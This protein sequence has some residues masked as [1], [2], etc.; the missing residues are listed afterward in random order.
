MDLKIVNEADVTPELNQA[1]LALLRTAFSAGATDF[2]E[3]RAWHGS[4]PAWSV[5]LYDAERMVAH[6]G[7]VERVV[8]VGAEQAGVA[9]IQNVAV[10]PDQRGK[11][12]CDKVMN[13][14]MS[15]AFQLGRDFGLLYC[16]PVLEKVYQRCN[17]ITLPGRTIICVDE[18]GRE[19]PIPAKNIAM[20]HPLQRRAFP[21]GDIHLQGNDW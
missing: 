2:A 5:L 11:G 9:G 7:I 3:T 10:A 16:L 8:R 18:H 13:A 19:V 6:V 17:W 1:I 20:Y 21:D 12:L 15:E 4:A 14:A